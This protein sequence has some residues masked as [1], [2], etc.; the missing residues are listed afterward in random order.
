MWNPASA[1]RH[2]ARAMG[3]PIGIFGPDAPGFEQVVRAVEE[4][5]GEEEQ[6][7]SRFRPTSELSRV[8]AAAGSWTPVS[9][10]FAALLRFGIAANTAAFAAYSSLRSSSSSSRCCRF[11]IRS[12]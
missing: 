7:Y 6:R 4:T 12:P 10:P 5:F 11:P 8:N 2:D 1:R 9:D 3:T